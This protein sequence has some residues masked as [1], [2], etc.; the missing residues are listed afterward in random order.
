MARTKSQPAAAPEFPP[1][2]VDESQTIAVMQ[3]RIDELLE[4]VSGYVEETVKLSAELKSARLDLEAARAAALP[5][6]HFAQ[7]QLAGYRQLSESD[8]RWI[9]R[10]KGLGQ[11]AR[12]LAEDMAPIMAFDANDRA[13]GTH[14]IRLGLML[15]VRSVAKPTEW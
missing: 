10:I 13:A 15:W 3:A 7:P 11:Q 8:A 14:H 6:G 5:A 9:N 12:E 2:P 4:Q 1:L